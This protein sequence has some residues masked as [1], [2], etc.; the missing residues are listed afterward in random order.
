MSQVSTPDFTHQLRE[1]ME[2]VDI[3]S[4]KALARAAG[5]SE[6]QILRLRRGD[7]E[8]MR[9]DTLIKLAEA[10]QMPLADL[11]TSFSEIK[12]PTTSS[13]ANDKTIATLKQEYQRLQLQLGQQR[14][15]LLQEFQSSSLQILESWL[16][17]WP[18]AAYKAQEN[19]QI[20]ATKLLPLMRPLQQLLQQWGVEAIAPVGA[21]VPYNP[22]LHQLLAGDT[23]PGK[24]VLVRYT[25]YLQGDRLL[26]RAKVSLLGS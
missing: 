3:S 5:V 26:Y 18:T 23:L 7:I 2:S 6:R 1:L 14:Q 15:T 25:G 21:K 17:Q 16:V 10:L 19:P 9:V 13:K 8:Q 22:Q 11:I 20:S 4:F 12:Y 24:E